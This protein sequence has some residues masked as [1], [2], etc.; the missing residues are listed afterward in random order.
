MGSRDFGMVNCGTVVYC[1][2]VINNYWCHVVSWKCEMSL[3]GCI[4]CMKMSKLH[5]IVCCCRDASEVW[6]WGGSSRSRATTWGWR[7]A[8]RTGSIWLP[9]WPGGIHI[10]ISAWLAS[11]MS[12]HWLLSL[13]PFSVLRKSMYIII[14]IIIIITIIIIIIP[15]SWWLVLI[16]CSYY[17]LFVY[18]VWGRSKL[19]DY[20]QQKA[21]SKVL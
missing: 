2:C 3:K 21:S 6:Q 14:V 12:Y 18:I 19:L 20:W 15:L 7:L 10:H 9:V 5:F 11:W 4:S 17:N 13:F 16:T 8:W 1:A